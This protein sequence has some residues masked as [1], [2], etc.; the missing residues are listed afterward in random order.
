[1]ADESERVVR[2]VPDAP[3]LPSGGRAE[4][5]RSPYAP[6]PTGLVRL[7]IRDR[8]L[9][10]CEPRAETGKVD[11]PTEQVGPDDPDGRAAAAALTRRVLGTPVEAEPVGFVRNVVPAGVPDYAWPTP[12]AHFTVW[13][14]SSTPVIPGSWIDLGAADCPLRDRHWWPIVA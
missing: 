4:I 5:V 9:V 1:M 3:W 13:S 12:I 14:A 2:V 8:E 11:L 10:F 6:T 7:L